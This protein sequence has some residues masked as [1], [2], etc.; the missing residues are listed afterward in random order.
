MTP[1]I[2]ATSP[3]SL[4]PTTNEQNETC[5]CHKSQCDCYNTPCHSPRKKRM[6][7]VPY[8]EY[9]KTYINTNKKRQKLQF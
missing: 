3:L 5:F 4:V 6:P 9:K 2:D 1:E 8:K 7:H